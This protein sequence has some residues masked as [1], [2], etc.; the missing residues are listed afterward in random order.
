M[1]EIFRL[2]QFAL[3]QTHSAHKIGTD[4]MLLGAFVAHHFAVTPPHQ[5]L[6]IGTG[7]GLIALMLAQAFTQ[8]HITGIE[9]DPPSAHEALANATGSPFAER[10]T[11]IEG[12]FAHFQPHT[13]YPLITSNPPYYTPTH[14]NS[15]PRETQAKHAI[16]LIPE[17]LFGQSQRL[18]T[19]EGTLATILA[20]SSLPHYITAAEQHHLTPSHHLYIHSK[21]HTPPKRVITLWQ[22]QVTPPTESHLTI[23]A[24]EG[25][26][27]Y[28]P[29]YT[30]LLHPYL[31][32][33]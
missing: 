14:H 15:D 24:G 10:V 4:G 27:Q 13:T 26:H 17:T 28:T 33:L 8:S 25:R 3:N 29:Q 5:V 23:L 31:T 22:K 11:I 6:D 30:H 16:T 32:I 20:Y 1:A 2:K 7:T 18:L 21:A 9:L 12:D 19:P